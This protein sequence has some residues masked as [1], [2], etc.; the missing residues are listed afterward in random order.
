MAFQQE[1]VQQGNLLFKNRSWLPIFMILPALFQYY[2]DV[3]NGSLPFQT[4]PKLEYWYA[5]CLVISH[6]GLFIRAITIGHTPKNTSGR[7]AT[8]GQIADQLNTSGIYSTVRHPLY[9]GNFFMWLGAALLTQNFWFVI[10]FIFAYMLYYERIMYAEEQF[11][12]TKF[13]NTYTQWANK[14][15]LII[16]S[17]THYTPS[18]LPFSLRNVLK[19]EYN[20]LLNIYL[21]LLA[22]QLINYFFA[23][24][25]ESFPILWQI[26]LGINLLIFIILRT[27][28]KKTTW[29]E[30]ADR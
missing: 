24:P 3:S 2:C 19:R 27:I 20:G 5:F 4:M 1:L 17:F 28:K 9:L 6:I 12:Q 7:N 23:V 18:T 11:L 21:V 30:V 29:L 26:I 22:F 14:T 15:P 25:P 13:G 10:A 16:P 8:E